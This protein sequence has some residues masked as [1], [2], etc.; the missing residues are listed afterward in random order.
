MIAFLGGQANS[1][2]S[3]SGWGGLTWHCLG[4]HYSVFD[5]AIGTAVE[6]ISGVTPSALSA[7]CLGLILSILIH[8]SAFAQNITITEAACV[9]IGPIKGAASTIKQLLGQVTVGSINFAGMTCVIIGAIVAFVFVT[10]VAYGGNAIFQHNH[11][12]TGYHEMLRPWIAI[13]IF[14]AFLTMAA[15]MFFGV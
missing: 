13:L 7:R 9:E 4:R 6:A 8:N 14:A 5:A 12:G 2:S 11:N 15:F 3:A 10:A 1:S